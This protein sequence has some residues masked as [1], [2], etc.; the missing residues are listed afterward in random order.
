MATGS[1]G[2]SDLR[3]INATPRLNSPIEP[4]R[5][6]VPS[7]NTSTMRP[8]SS[9]R[10]ISLIEAGSPPFSL[11]GTALRARISGRSQPIS[12]NPA[13]ARKS[14]CRPPMTDPMMGGS[15]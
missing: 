13:R 4:S 3:R 8:C 1:T 7:G 15:R 6:R 10:R 9:R 11:T 12:N 5:V 14:K 2:H